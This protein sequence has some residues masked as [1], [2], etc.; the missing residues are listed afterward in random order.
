M[1][2]VGA[3]AWGGVQHEEDDYTWEWLD[4]VIHVRS[5]FYSFNLPGQDLLNDT[6]T[7][8]KFEGTLPELARWI[9][10]NRSKPPKKV[11]MGGE[12]TGKGPASKL[13]IAE[14]TTVEE[15]LLDAGVE[16]S[17]SDERAMAQ[18]RNP[19][20]SVPALVDYVLESVAAP[21]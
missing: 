13:E 21:Q 18:E 15:A 6:V 3:L 1:E 10:E 19:F 5:R 11:L 14:G 2:A 4:G 20:A 12:I 8:G 9:N 7:A 16:V 17:L